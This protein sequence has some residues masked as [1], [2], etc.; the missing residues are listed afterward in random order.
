MIAT[1]TGAPAAL[2]TQAGARATRLLQAR[3]AA[4]WRR[5]A[6]TQGV[7]TTLGASSAKG[8][9]AGSPWC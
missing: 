3:R 8:V 1:W 7:T 9:A 2:G 4:P 5:L 6:A